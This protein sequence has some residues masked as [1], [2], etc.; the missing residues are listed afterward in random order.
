MQVVLS[1]EG[2]QLLYILVTFGI[3]V[4]VA[5]VTK[6][7]A[8]PGV[9]AVVLAVLTALAAALAPVLDTGQFDLVDT[10]LLWLQGIVTAV[11]AHYGV[12]K[13]TGVTGSTGKAAFVLPEKGVGKAQASS[14]GDV[15]VDGDGA[16]GEQLELPSH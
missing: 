14:Y 15:Q 7:L 4:L 16:D 3:P 12:L 8:S 9:K 13:P 5:V 2:A 10:L 1:S 6:R 11:A